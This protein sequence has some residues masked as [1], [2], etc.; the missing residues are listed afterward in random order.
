[1]KK[2]SLIMV[3]LFL[4][5]CPRSETMAGTPQ[6]TWDHYYD[7][8]MV[9]DAL[10][11]MHKAWPNLTELQSLGQSAE[12]RDIWC[13]TIT[14]EKTGS[15]ESKPAMYVDGA[16]HGNE[17]QATE[18]CL[19]TAWTLLTKY[20]QW[21][22]ITEL[23]DEKSF[24]IIPTINVDNR[25][26]FFTDPGGYSIGRSARIP[27]DD[28]GDGLLD[29][30]PPNDL[31]GD[32]R[33]LQM[34]IK[35]PN[36]KWKTHPDDPRVMVRVKH[37]EKGEWTRLYQEGIDDDGDGRINED[38]PGYLDM[39][40]NWGYLWQPRS[41][42]TGSGDFPF[43]ASNTKAVADFI[44]Q[45]PNIAFGFAFH[46]YGGMFLRGPG[47]KLSPPLPS[48][49]LLVFDYLGREGERTVPGY[50]YLVSMSDLYT[51]Y[52]DF[53][54]FMYQIF[55]IYAYVGELYMSSQI[56]Y[57]GYREDTIG[58][59]GNLWSRRPGY[60]ERQQFNDHLMMGE[61]FTEWHSFEHPSYGEIEI[62]G[63]REFS[64]RSS[65]AWMLP[66]MLHRNAMFVIWTAGQMPKV[67]LEVFEVVNLGGNL[68]RVRA[69]AINSGAVPTLSSRSREMNLV[70]ADQFSLQGKNVK[71]LSGGLL[72]DSHLNNVEPVEFRPW[73]VGT[74]IS[75]FGTRE[76]QW[77][78]EGT[79]K[80]QVKY[81][82][83]KCG[84]STVEGQVH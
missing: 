6:L 73:R 45:R 67:S 84:I 75:A 80:F 16:I 81:D 1:M 48:D 26:R 46:N 8:E 39:N 33:I 53:D 25:A 21:D 10:K 70:R 13:L 60:V 51:T 2:L 55:G 22:R 78:V 38:H 76:V 54:E 19:Y 24:Y 64:V 28:D 69:R 36:G 61:M 23:L 49:D 41:V 4:F 58:K 65:P 72:L 3:V 63:W 71:V 83:V 17:I 9:T 44:L 74:F 40:R 35:D 20:G 66:D 32:G 62:G 29:E 30:D 82:G 5:C 42:Q 68:H 27:Y 37:G 14:N 52:G 77:I 59:D 57:R 50:R 34:R 11:Q 56:A 18:V 47:S 43:S 79:G 7:Q 31:D 15:A 12:G